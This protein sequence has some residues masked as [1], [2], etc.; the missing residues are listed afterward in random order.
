MVL[1]DARHEA[2][3]C[4]SLHLQHT[5]KHLTSTLAG[6]HPLTGSGQG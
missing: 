4:G 2:L 5:L 1:K 6:L 3:A